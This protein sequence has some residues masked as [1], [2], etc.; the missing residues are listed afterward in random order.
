MKKFL[1][2]LGNLILFVVLMSPIIA[3]MW[4]LED[5]GINF[6]HFSLILFL[7][8]GLLAF[9]GIKKSESSNSKDS[10]RFIFFDFLALL[11]FS[12]FLLG[13]FFIA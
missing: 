11:G 10:N 7:V 4:F 2:D 12:L 1:R 8:G 5:R 3:L 13:L 9:F 6:L